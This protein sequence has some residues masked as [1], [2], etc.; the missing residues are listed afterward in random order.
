VD[1]TRDILYRSVLLNDSSAEDNVTGGGGTGTGITGNILDSFDL[2]DVDIIQWNEK[3]SQADGNDAG[4]VFQGMR[5]IRISGTCY[6]LTRGLL[7]DNL[8]ALRAALNPV[9]AQRE[10]PL[11]HGYRPFYFSVPTNRQADYP[12]GAIDLLVYAMPRAFQQVTNSDQI[13]GDDEDSLGVTWMATLI[14]KDPGIYGVDARDVAF[15]ATANFASTTTAAFATD[16][17]TTG[18]AHGLAVNDR[19]TFSAITGNTSLVTGTTYYV[20]T[21]PLSTTFTLSATLGG[22]TFDVA[23]SNITASTWVKSSSASG[24]W[25]NRG[26]YLGIL[27]AV[28]EVGAG[29]GTI[30][31]T[32]GDSVFTVTVPASTHN[33]II[34]IKGADKMLTFEESSVETPQMSRI[35]FTGDTTW[36]LIDPGDTPYSI[37]FHGMSGVVTGS[38]MWFY[39]QYA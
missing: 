20:K 34:R 36:P 16:L 11:D 10:E 35:V 37:T 24:T 15:T 2:S 33:R 14:C 3:R 7:F 22:A 5:R 29:A 31:A 12:A 17:F 19:I 26:T 13:G 8:F 39:E 21:T 25:S 28:I 18:A 4:D 6:G 38:H 32:V 1:T 23:T 27:N 30:S 9:L